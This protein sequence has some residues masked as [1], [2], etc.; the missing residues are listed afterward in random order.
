MGRDRGQHKAAVHTAECC[1]SAQGRRS[2][3]YV[4]QGVRPPHLDQ[5]AAGCCK[6]LGLQLKIVLLKLQALS[7]ANR[8]IVSHKQSSHIAGDSA[9]NRTHVMHQRASPGRH[10]AVRDNSATVRGF[11][12]PQHV[13]QQQDK[14]PSRL[15]KKGC[16]PLGRHSCHQLLAAPRLE[17]CHCDRLLQ[18]HAPGRLCV[19]RLVRVVQGGLHL[20]CCLLDGVQLK[21]VLHIPAGGQILKKDSEN[22]TQE[23]TC[24]ACFG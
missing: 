24:G 23:R 8:Q 16:S 12:S 4:L 13:Q 7:T 14:D 20:V 11:G 3:I 2:H 21:L 22:R 9:A 10:Q 17:P 1:K 19:Q 15:W 5:G 6:G 18:C